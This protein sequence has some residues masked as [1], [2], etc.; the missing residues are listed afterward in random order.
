MKILNL[1]S[2]NLIVKINLVQTT[3][4][5]RFCGRLSLPKTGQ[6]CWLAWEET[7]FP[8]FNKTEHVTA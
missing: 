2:F 7:Y 1:I 3:F 4:K 6:D 8:S 5:I